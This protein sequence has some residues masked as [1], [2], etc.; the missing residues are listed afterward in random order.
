MII[1]R[2][3]LHNIRSYLDSSVILPQGKILF[4]GNIGS[5]KSTILLALEF[6]LF[7]LQRGIFDGATL[8]RNGKKDGYVEVEFDVPDHN[9]IIKRNLKRSKDSV[10]Q[11]SA[12]LTID[13]R[14]K[15]LTAMELKSFILEVL[16]YP[17]SLLTKKNL[18]YRYTVYTPQEEMKRI[19]LE[20]DED[21]LDTLRKVL[22]IDKYKK[23]ITNSELFVQDLKEKIKQKEGQ[24]TD[25]PFKQ[26]QMEKR[27]NSLKEII[28]QLE[29]LAPKL[30]LYQKELLDLKKILMTEQ[31]NIQILNDSKL[32]FTKI[33]A[34]L[35]EKQQQSNYFAKER[36][37][38][39]PLMEKLRQELK[40][41]IDIE[42]IKNDKVEKQE[43]LKNG[44]ANESV[45]DRE[46]AILSSRKQKLEEDS[47]KISTLKVCPVCKQ[48]VTFEHKD[49]IATE[50]HE[51]V[52]KINT[53]LEKK[54]KIMA[55]LRQEIEKL[56]KEMEKL[57]EKEREAMALQLKHS[58]LEEKESRLS[59]LDE[60]IKFL[61]ENIVKLETEK[62]EEMELINKYKDVETKT[63]RLTKEI[64]EKQRDERHLSMS[65]SG[66]EQNKIDLEQEIGELQKEIAARRKISEKMAEFRA[67]QEFLT[68][69]FSFIING[70]EKRILLR[71]SFE[72]NS[73]FRKWFSMLVDDPQL[74]ATVNEDFKP[75]ISQAGYEI[76]YEYLSGGER[77]ALALAYRLALNQIINSMLSK[78]STKDLLILD[79]PTDGFSSEQLDRMR[80]VLEELKT[81]QL[82]LV[83]HEQKMEEFVETVLKFVKQGHISRIIQ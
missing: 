41:K 14:K 66:I 5:G 15:E 58:N 79:E 55:E 37:E 68:K 60:T 51:E 36:D 9:I 46:I 2:I 6:A 32:K 8:L 20:D 78:I 31:R 57:N 30:K 29:I 21:R 34:E 33:T 50:I 56:E 74:D 44:K 63:E 67:F 53:E 52:E 10:V 70:M 28:K 23:I 81:K 42:K 38:L 64:D 49:K 59:K 25:L 83:S 24:L 76:N 17:P 27:N 22:S 73:L 18:I 54:T 1:K 75:V 12:T 71:L 4:S 61:S 45:F 39:K 72:F 47:R 13:D 16:N 82:I 77:T 40:E 62:E 11:D 26:E 19:L 3:R 43:F 48:E 69:N 80:Q 35:Y 65:Y 7:G